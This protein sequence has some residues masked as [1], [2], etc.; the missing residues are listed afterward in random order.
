MDEW[1]SAILQPRR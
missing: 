1:L